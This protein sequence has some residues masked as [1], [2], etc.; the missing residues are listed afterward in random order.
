MCKLRDPDV[1]PNAVN[2]GGVSHHLDNYHRDI[3]DIVDLVQRSGGMENQFQISMSELANRLQR[4]KEKSQRVEP[5]VLQGDRDRLGLESIFGVVTKTFLS[6]I[7][8]MRW[9]DLVEEGIE[10][11]RFEAVK[12]SLPLTSTH[13]IPPP[14]HEDN[15]SMGDKVKTSLKGMV[16][17]QD[18]ST[19][20]PK[21][22]GLRDL[23]VRLVDKEDW[24]LLSR[25]DRGVK[26]MVH[27][28]GVVVGEEGVT[29]N[30]IILLEGTLFSLLL[31]DR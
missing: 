5:R 26:V 27:T 16:F 3:D 10:S 2:V 7:G 18:P 29:I 11:Q 23:Q 28:M 8:N 17:A 9:G 6:Q 21:T 25:G 22:L 12:D 14:S 20:F 30:Q 15:I 24:G 19:S 31:R 13:G 4:L 1:V